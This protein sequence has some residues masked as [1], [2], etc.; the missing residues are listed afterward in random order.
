M[1]AKEDLGWLVLHVWYLTITLAEL[2]V[3]CEDER[4]SSTGLR[5]YRMCL[6]GVSLSKLQ[7]ATLM[8]PTFQ[9]D[10]VGTLPHGESDLL[11]QPRVAKCQS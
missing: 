9:R 10:R 2:C 4:L 1:L 11:S 6:A 3:N 7:Q 8:T 5:V